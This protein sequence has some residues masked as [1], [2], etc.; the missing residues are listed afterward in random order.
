MTRRSERPD[1]RDRLD[2]LELA[3]A[4]R[5]PLTSALLA[6]GLLDDG[7]LGALNEA[8]RA[9]LASLVGD[10]DRLRTRV[11]QGLR[12]EPLG[13]YVGPPER[14]RL[15][16]G[17]LADEA[18]APLQAQARACGVVVAVERAEARVLGDPLKLRWVVASLVGNALRYASTRV[19]LQ[20]RAEHRTAL[21]EVGDD[22][23]GM[24]PDLAARLFERD[25]PG[26][27]L[28]LV[29]EV[30]EAHGGV[31]DVLLDGALGA[32]FA[33]RLPLAAHR[34]PT[35]RQRKQP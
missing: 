2:R 19:Q 31:I 14:R 34:G 17:L 29:R 3:H 13:S 15:E 35:P 12:T 8:Q 30:V 9:A 11:E 4:L 27:T 23:P 5:T 20:V 6:A 7:T 33:V 10:L 25:G 26:L 21:L 32:R 22:G 28:Y 1:A 16:L 24:P 18:I